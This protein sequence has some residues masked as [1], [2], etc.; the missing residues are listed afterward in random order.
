MTIL[1]SVQ[2]GWIRWIV[3]GF[4]ILISGSPCWT[5][6]EI[7]RWGHYVEARLVRVEV[8]TEDVGGNSPAVVQ[9][10]NIITVTNG[11]L[12][13]SL[14]HKFPETVSP[15]L[16][17]RDDR[18]AAPEGYTFG[19]VPKV[20][21]RLGVSALLDVNANADLA[22]SGGNSTVHLQQIGNSSALQQDYEM[23]LAR[24]RYDNRGSLKVEHGATFLASDVFDGEVFDINVNVLLR[25]TYALRVVPV[26]V[27]GGV[28]G[29]D[30]EV[31]FHDNPGVAVPATDFMVLGPR[32]RVV[33]GLESSVTVQITDGFRF[34]GQFTL[35]EL[36]DLR[37]DEL[38]S[39]DRSARTRFW[40][41][42]GE[43]STEVNP[44]HSVKS[45][46]HVKT[47]TAVCGVRGTSL[48]VSHDTVTD[49]SEISVTHGGPVDLR[50]ADLTHSGGMLR[51]GDQ[52][53][54][55]EVAVDGTYFDRVEPWAFGYRTAAVA[56]GDAAAGIALAANGDA[57][58]LDDLTGGI[59]RV[60]PTGVRTAFYSP[61][62]AEE[63]GGWFGPLLRAD[64]STLLVAHGATGTVY[65]IS[66]GGVRSEFAVVE[67]KRIS[68]LALRPD[69]NAC[70]TTDDG[71]LQEINGAGVVTEIAMDLGD[72]AFP[73]I[74]ADGSLSF[75]LDDSSRIFRW[76]GTAVEVVA[77]LPG[78]AG[79]L[80]HVP[81]LGLLVSYGPGGAY[82]RDT[83]A[84]VD[85]VSGGLTVLARQFSSVTGVAGSP[86]GYFVADARE[87]T[88]LRFTPLP[89]NTP[90]VS[91]D[92]T[93]LL[94][95]RT[96]IGADSAP[97]EVTLF[98]TGTASVQVT[99]LAC[100]DTRFTIA[101]D[102]LPLT[103]PVG[104]S[105]TISVIFA[106]DQR[107]TVSAT[108]LITTTD[109]V[110]ADRHVRLEGSG[111]IPEIFG[112]DP[113]PVAPG[114]LVTLHVFDAG[115]DPDKV[116]LYADGQPI[117]TFTLV[118]SDLDQGV[119]TLGF[120]LPAGLPPGPVSFTLRVGG[121]ES[122]AFDVA[123][124]IPS[125]PR[126]SLDGP[127]GGS[128]LFPTVSTGETASIDV[129]IKNRGDAAL[130][131]SDALAD[132][133]FTLTA[134]GLPLVLPPGAVSDITLTCNPSTEGDIFGQLQL[135]SNDSASP[136]TLD[137]SGRGITYDPALSWIEEHFPTAP[138]K[139]GPVA[140][141]DDDTLPNLLERAAGL[142]PTLSDG[143]A[144][145]QIGSREVGASITCIVRVD[146]F[147][148]DTLLVL[149]SSENLVDWRPLAHY[150]P[151]G[152]TVQRRATG[153]VHLLESRDVGA[154]RF[155]T[156]QILPSV[157][158]YIR[159]RVLGGE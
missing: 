12:Q 63:T 19:K 54:V 22:A 27:I 79:W 131:I 3:S 127:G 55:S 130:S 129:R 128:V 49:S 107:P 97:L 16:L 115:S 59:M 110:I 123:S 96:P 74:A 39:T 106:P 88:V 119:G 4:G 135:V 153:H 31:I 61:N 92:T 58:I 117:T 89:S 111:G 122:P 60:T 33:T 45:D 72:P 67:A 93:H 11:H 15:T 76:T 28:T 53:S 10:G 24:G 145:V 125:G 101:S 114:D 36:T 109:P 42:A 103:L 51:Q 147:A 138:E 140:D 113:E 98:N 70:V 87:S 116:E 47:P 57:L 37:V 100:A 9:D 126:L 83:L 121:V 52:V 6:A 20:T 112:V 108:L 81:G 105:R 44:T 120:L 102:V 118:E 5:N 134:P 99:S 68:G 1:S 152:H 77:N 158:G 50:P 154:V 132:A 91:L 64:G 156:E 38:I 94:F 78:Q 13:V 62:P 73:A 124:G 69:G 65:E 80:G 21:G 104:A 43:V 40:L 149:E 34:Q 48:T 141:P 46:F 86:A 148:E 85:P 30:V 25:A 155:H 23:D 151:E 56:I 159:L 26:A 66:G 7:P 71:T 17:I 75:L 2:Q 150:R 136:Y 157:G 32:D 41:E 144:P 8:V 35:D 143:D 146:R 142:D 139:A 133:P 82:D 90:Q 14:E 18:V 29:S 95:P 137:L 84:S